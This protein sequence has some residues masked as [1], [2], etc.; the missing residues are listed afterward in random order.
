MTHICL[1]CSKL[2]SIFVDESEH[3]RSIVRAQYIS[4]LIY[5]FDLCAS[6]VSDHSQK[7]KRVH[8]AERKI[9]KLCSWQSWAALST[10]SI[11]DKRAQPHYNLRAKVCAR[12]CRVCILRGCSRHRATISINCWKRVTLAIIIVIANVNARTLSLR[13][14]RQPSESREYFQNNCF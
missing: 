3:N 13:R 5:N 4:A 12:S 9:S 8:R 2:Y 6:R 10:N 14:A 7:V 1:L 11:S